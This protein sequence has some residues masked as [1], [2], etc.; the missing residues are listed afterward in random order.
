MIRKRTGASGRAAA[1]HEIEFYATERIGRTAFYL[2]F[3]A[4]FFAGF[5]AAFFALAGFMPPGLCF[6][7]LKAL[8]RTALLVAAAAGKSVTVTV[9]E[10]GSSPGFERNT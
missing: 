8:I 4:G 6:M 2:I 3:F 9:A 1:D 10:N 7:R 5:F